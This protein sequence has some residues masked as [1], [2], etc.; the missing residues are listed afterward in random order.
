VRPARE[1]ATSLPGLRIKRIWDDEHLVEYECSIDTG[2]FRGSSTCYAGHGALEGFSEQLQRFSKAFEG[3]AVF[4]AGLEDGTNAVNIRFFI[5]DR[6]KRVVV[7]VRLV[8]D[9]GH[10]PDD[11]A[12]LEVQFAVEAAAID[13]FIPQVK[14]VR[15]V[16]DSAFLRAAI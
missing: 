5:I 10:R 14:Q 6:A 13:E 12:R 1:V 16:G 4:D 15:A 7:A 9:R 3:T 2:T 11:V 8:T